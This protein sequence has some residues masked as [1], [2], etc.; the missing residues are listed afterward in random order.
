[1]GPDIC[2]IFASR[3]ERTMKKIVTVVILALMA[4]G[5]NAK[6]VS[7]NSTTGM[8]L[9]ETAG[10]Y[11]LVGK[12]GVIILGNLKS[13]R[14]F[15]FSANVCFA[16]EKLQEVIDCGEQKFNVKEDEEG[17]YIVKVGLGGVKVRPSDTAKFFT[18]LESR[19]IKEKAKKVWEDVTE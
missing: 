12:S 15:M 6:E 13:A 18:W 5:M 10:V 2:S 9:D 1:M 19:I 11:S 17:L 8:V 7:R 3:K 16:Q 4:V 14:D